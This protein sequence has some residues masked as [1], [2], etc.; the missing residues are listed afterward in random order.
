MGTQI[1]IVRLISFLAMSLSGCKDEQ[2]QG[3]VNCTEEFRSTTLYVPGAPLTESFTIRLSNSD[4]IRIKGN[5]DFRQGYYVVL[6]DNY[7]TK[8]KNQ[9]DN[10]RFIGKRGNEVV[11]QE[12]YVFKADQ[13]HITKISGKTSL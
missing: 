4:T 10:F 5:A 7:Q 2:P 9:Q 13:C 8:L 6:D 3:G 11:V 12:N 1:S